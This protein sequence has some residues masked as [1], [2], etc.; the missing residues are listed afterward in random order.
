[1]SAASAECAQELFRRRIVPYFAEP[2]TSE[3]KG[4]AVPFVENF[5]PYGAR[6]QNFPESMRVLKDPRNEL[7][8]PCLREGSKLVARKDATQDVFLN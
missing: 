8:C 3:K 2:E 4:A 1:M 6:E 7:T 5:R